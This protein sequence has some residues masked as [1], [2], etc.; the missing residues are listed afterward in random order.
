MT[1]KKLTPD[2]SELLDM[3]DKKQKFTIGDPAKAKEKA[4]HTIDTHEQKMKESLFRD[5]MNITLGDYIN[6]AQSFNREMF[7]TKV[8]ATQEAAF[9][10]LFA[11]EQ[12][13]KRISDH[14]E[15]IN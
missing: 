9:F 3:L 14:Y 13:A 6:A 2:V 4:M 7:G 10:T 8:D 11:F 15:H 5:F 12:R 1:K